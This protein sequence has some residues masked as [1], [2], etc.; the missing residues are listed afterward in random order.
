[1]YSILQKCKDEKFNLSFV[2]N[3]VIE[4]GQVSFVDKTDKPDDGQVVFEDEDK[5]YRRS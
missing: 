2:S 5:K 4:D 1:L 3:A